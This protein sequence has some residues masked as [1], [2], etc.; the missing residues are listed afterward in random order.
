MNNVLWKCCEYL[1][2]LK[3]ELSSDMKLIILFLHTLVCFTSTNTWMVLK[4]KNMEILKPGM[5]QLCANLMGQLFHRGFY[6]VLKDLLIKGLGRST[7]A[8]KS[9]SLS[10][11]QTLALRPL[12][13]ANFSDKFMTTFLINM[14]SVPGLIYHLQNLSPDTVSILQQQNIFR[15]CLELLSSQQSMRIVF[16][17]LE[18]SYALCLLANLIQLGYIER[19][20]TLV[21]LCFPTFTV[22]ITGLLES[23]QNYV[24]NKQSALTHWHPILGWFAQPIDPCINAAISYVKTQLQLLWNVEMLEIILGNYLNDIVVGRN[25]I[26]QQ[27]Q[28]PTQSFGKGNFLKKIL[29]KGGS[30]PSFSKNYH[31]LGS[32]E[33]HRVVL[34][35][36]LYHTA[37]RTLTQLQLNILTGFCYQNFILS[38]LWMFIYSLG[39]NCGLK[40]FL[41]HLAFST[42]CSAPEF[43]MLQLFTDCMIHYVTLLD[44]IEMYEEPKLFLLDDYESISHF[45]N[46]FLCKAILGNLFD[47][48]SI[49][50]NSLFQSLHT[51]LMVLYKRDCR[52]SY[53][54]PGHW[55]IKDIKV[56]SFLIDLE[57]GRRA[58]QLL[59]QTMPHI[60]PHE[61]RVRLFRKYIA[62][63]KTV[64]GLTESACASPQSTLITVHRTKKTNVK[65]LQSMCSMSRKLQ[66][67]NTIRYC[68]LQ[69]I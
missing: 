46:T 12:I 11:I 38:N 21:D 22:V 55:L 16:N 39:P 33:V 36:S 5:N 25:S 57:K 60:I 62:N 14:F 2:K 32:L 29:E 4:N 69:C 56:S 54:S 59:L 7:I 68:Q 30:K 67:N 17:T 63:E 31:G 34:S 45:L 18:G 50:S 3:P 43:H 8:F 9:A 15:R 51:L 19:K 24:V 41:D 27:L 61:D 66:K 52:R 37:L 47:I 28:C 48:K 10:A 40:T 58:P 23:C 26:A 35:C 1:Q 49:H 44:D 13:S 6:L 64:L 53:T 20:T 65:W 42:K